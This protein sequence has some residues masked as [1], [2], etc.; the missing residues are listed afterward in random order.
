MI[1]SLRD[2]IAIALTVFVVTPSAFAACPANTTPVQFAWENASGVGAKWLYGAVENTYNFNYTNTQGQA[3]SVAVTVKLRDPD[4]INVDPD[5]RDS[6]KHPYDP[7]GS[8]K[9]STGETTDAWLGDG[10]INDPWDSD[11]NGDPQKLST[12]T[13]KAYGFPFFTWAVMSSH[14]EQTAYLDFQFSKPTYMDNFTVG[15]IDSVGLTYTFNNFVNTESPGNSYQD[16]VGFLASKNGSAVPVDL[17]NQGSGLLIDGTVARSRYDTNQNYN[18]AP[19]DP[20]GT[21]S[22]K[23]VQPFDTFTLS[24]S[25]G[26]ADADDEQANPQLYTWWSNTNGATN[27]ASDNHAVRFAGFTFCVAEPPKVD[28]N[29]SKSVSKSSVKPGDAVV[30]TLTA[31]NSGPDA[32]SGVEIKDLLPTGLTHVSDDSAGQYDPVTGKWLVGDLGNGASK[33]LQITMII[34]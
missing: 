30:Y 19:D 2:S 15:D 5:V 28:I 27:G 23:T 34:K 8:C 7:A 26:K 6:S 22:A 9:P 12:G 4:N 10:S 31:T 33:S 18:V 17:F 25:N 20:I 32:A 29:L 14:H 3:D 21:V 13:G 1:I 11:C 24:Y 16:E